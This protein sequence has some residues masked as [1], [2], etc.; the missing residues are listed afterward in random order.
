MTVTGGGGPVAPTLIG[1]EAEV[2]VDGSIV[3]LEDGANSILQGLDLADLL[4]GTNPL[5]DITVYGLYSDGSR[6]DVTSLAS[7]NCPTVPNPVIGCVAGLDSGGLVDIV[8]LLLAGTLDADHP[9]NVTYGGF[10]A[11]VVVRLDLPVL[12]S[13]GFGPGPLAL[14]VGNQLPALQALFSQGVSS[15]VDANAPDLTYDIDLA[16]TGLISVINAIPLVGP[17]LVGDLNEVIDGLSVVNGVLTLAPGLTDELD[18]LL[19]NPLLSGILGG[20]LPLKLTGMLD[21]VVFDD[22]P[23]NLGN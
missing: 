7:V 17:A 18:G 4:D 20:V 2:L 12:Q 10:T 16:N 8:S 19:S 11:N 3:T 21:G 15:T 9:I 14:D 5:A 22:V 23:L 6:Q 13:L 1:L